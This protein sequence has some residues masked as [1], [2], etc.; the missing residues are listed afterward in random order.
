[1]EERRSVKTRPTNL[2]GSISEQ[3]VDIFYIYFSIWQKFP[4]SFV[5]LYIHLKIAHVFVM[6]SLFKKIMLSLT[7]FVSPF[8][9]KYHMF[10]LHAHF[11]NYPYFFDLLFHHSFDIITSLHLCYNPFKQFLKNTSINTTC[12]I[13]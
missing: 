7:K 4:W 5:S 13:F 11:Q 12:I 3:V 8:F 9:W 6:C 10:M 1:M 2:Q